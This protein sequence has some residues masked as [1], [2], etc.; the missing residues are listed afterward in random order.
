MMNKWVPKLVRGLK[1]EDEL[2]GVKPTAGHV[3]TDEQL[4]LY[5]EKG[6]FQK[7]REFFAD[8]VPTINLT[9]DTAAD[10][11][12]RDFDA[13]IQEAEELKKEREKDKALIEKQRLKIHWR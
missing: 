6:S 1:F 3:P 4:L 8:Q 10:V 7:L 9:P 2:D 13:K 12:V 5:S 11:D